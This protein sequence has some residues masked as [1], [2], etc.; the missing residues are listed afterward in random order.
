MHDY[1]R[2]FHRHY[3]ERRMEVRKVIEIGVC[4]GESL[5]MWEQYFPNAMIYGVDINPECKRHESNRVKVF[6]GSQADT[7]FMNDVMDSVG[8]NVDLINDDGSH[9]AD[10]QILG[11]QLWF[12]HLVDGGVYAIEDIGVH[13]HEPARRAVNTA[14]S[15]LIHHVN[16]WPPNVPGAAWPL[17]NRFPSEAPWLAR[18]VLGVE[19]YRF[20]TFII[21]G[22]NPEENPYLTNRWSWSR[23]CQDLEVTV[24][25]LGAKGFRYDPK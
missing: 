2:H 13:E 12:P 18:N 25:E 9:E 3:A 7:T 10:H 6:I 22:R 14:L 17:V 5:R 15:E 19:F 20:I 23:V 1:L 4:G 8:G 21:R 24:N 11:F 16:Y